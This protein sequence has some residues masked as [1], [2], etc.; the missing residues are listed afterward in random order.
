MTP[1]EQRALFL[2]YTESISSSFVYERL[3]FLNVRVQINVSFQIVC[4]GRRIEMPI[5][6]PLPPQRCKRTRFAATATAAAQRARV[7]V[8]SSAV[9]PPLPALVTTTTTTHL[10]CGPPRIIPHPRHLQVIIACDACDRD[11]QSGE[12]YDGHVVVEDGLSRDDGD[13]F[14]EDAT[15]AERDDVR[16]LEQCVFRGD[17]A[18]GQGAREEEEASGFGRVVG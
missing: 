15:Y 6:F 2:S 1:R 4:V 13:D 17:H 12:V 3:R 10:R 11:E 8:F 14:L 5:T 18:E 9:R 7:V 16:A